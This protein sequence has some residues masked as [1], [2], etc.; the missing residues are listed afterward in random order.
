MI[1][2]QHGDRTGREI[3]TLA[4]KT[5]GLPAGRGAGRNRSLE[6]GEPLFSQAPA[7]VR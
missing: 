1:H 3:L 2:V 6:P 7:R 4:Q 5:M